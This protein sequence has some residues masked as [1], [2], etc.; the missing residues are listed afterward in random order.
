MSGVALILAGHGSHISP[1]T[2]GIVWAY[3]DRLRSWGVAAE[4]SACFWKEPPAFSQILATVCA[5]QVVVVPVFTARGYFSSEVIPTE[6]GLRGSVTECGGKTVQLMATIGEHPLLESIVERRLRDLVAEYGLRPEETA[7]AIIG[8]G[9]PRNRHSRDATQQQADRIRAL[10]WLSEVVAV[11]LDD[12]PTIPSIYH[13]TRAENIIALPYFLAQGSHV[14]Q[15]LPRA[16]GITGE[17]VP[18]RAQ[19][20]NIYYGE[21]VGTDESICQVILELA[22]ESGLPFPVAEAAVG[23]W[24]GFP[25]AGSQELME[26]LERE[27]TLRFGQL[28]VSRERVWHGEEAVASRAIGSPAALRA[29][30]RERPFRPL[31]TSTD[32]PSGW[33]VD[34]AEQRQ[35]HAVIETV[36]PGLVADWA[37]Q[38]RGDL[39]TESL[40]GISGRQGG[41]FKDIDKLPEPV[42]RRTVETV[43][44]NCIRQPTWYAP[45]EQ[46]DLPCRA[47]CN[48]WLSTARKLGGA[49]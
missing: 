30:L 26:A 32:L 43:C 34:L 42:V 41:M 9:T 49:A 8:H 27:G 23:S 22:R 4:V 16:L 18:E 7:A 36:Y 40:V 10:N 44:G 38:K 5:E 3:V 1:N 21:A 17:K 13:S 11:Y 37:A 45:N 2:A 14:T 20:R 15:D 35:A 31:P 46:A 33:H 12:E 24:D 6:M 48:L 19:G 28:I 39:Q 47:A 25:L 29:H